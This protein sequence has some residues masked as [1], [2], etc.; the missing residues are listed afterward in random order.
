MIKEI[1]DNNK[2]ISILRKV[3]HK[4]IIIEFIF[5]FIKYNT[6]ILFELIEKDKILASSINS[7]FK[8][9]KKNNNLSQTIDYNSKFYY[10]IRFSKNIYLITPLMTYIHLMNTIPQKKILIHL[11]LIIN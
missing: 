6:Y 9:V 4:P 5:S 3:K 10:S 2:Y 7:Y 1:I 11:L 8:S